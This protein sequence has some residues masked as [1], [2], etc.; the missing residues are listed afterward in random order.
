MSIP[1]QNWSWEE[2]RA[3]ILEGLDAMLGRLEE[4][5]A[6]TMAAF[7][8]S[9]PRM[10]SRYD[11]RKE[12]EGATL[13]RIRCDR[14]SLGLLREEI[15]EVDSS[16]LQQGIA[17]LG[18]FVIYEASWSDGTEAVFLWKVGVS[19]LFEEHVLQILSV[20]TPVGAIL[21]GGQ[22]CLT[23]EVPGSGDQVT[24]LKVLP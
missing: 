9:P 8:D 24:I 19:E 1:L 11:T 7:L 21:L 18:S 16:K 20:K 10:E 6:F 14:K 13:G 4:S 2:L 12:D 15:V 17:S 3:H 23:R 22:K 5:E